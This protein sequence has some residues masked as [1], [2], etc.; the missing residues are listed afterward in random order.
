MRIEE[1]AAMKVEHLTDKAFRVM[2]AKN[3]NSVR[4][5]PIHPAIKPMVSRLVETSGDGY[6]VS[7]LLTGGADGKRSHYASR[8]FG[9]FLRSHGF[10][11]KTL[12]FHS[13]R[14]SFTQRCEQAEIPE[15]T[16]KLLTGHSR[17]SLT[18]G[19]YS[20]GPEFPSLETALHKIGYG[21]LTDKHVRE[22]AKDIKVTE[23]MRRR[24]LAPR[25]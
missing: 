6:L 25:Q 16:A 3:E 18:Y 14:R 17:Q 13:L 8:Y 10:T 15:S 24:A 12:T 11:D 21:D 9:N 7:G 23:M 2:E 19:L 4:Y 5:V 20:P 1:I 22:L